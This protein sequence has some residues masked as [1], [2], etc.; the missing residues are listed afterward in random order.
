MRQYSPTNSLTPVVK[1]LVI[2]NVLV[3]I[4]QYYFAS[5]GTPLENYGALWSIGSGNFKV[6][7]LVTH[8]F[9]H[10]SISHIVFNMFALWMFGNTLERF[11][12]PKRFLEFY[13]MCGIFAGIAQLLLQRNGASAIG[14]SGAIMGVMAAFAYLFPNTELFI[15]FIP[16]PVKAKYAISGL[17]L[18]DIFGELVPTA[19]DNIAHYAHLGGALAGLVIVIIW[20]RK[21]RKNFY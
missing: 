7:Q 2:A 11:W 12:G 9:M 16:I 21:N 3:F 20:N 5:I 6:W 13:F 19:N 8:L 18:Y 14:A 1:N 15:L 17:I 10:G 4:A